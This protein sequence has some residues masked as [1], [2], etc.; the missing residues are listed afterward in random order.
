MMDKILKVIDEKVRPFLAEHNGDIEVLR[1][2]NGI[3]EI[4]L[5]GACSGC[6]SSKFTV[7]ELVEAPLMAEIPEIKEVVLVHYINEETMQFARKI[8]HKNN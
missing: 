6:M 5:L 1:F 4:K 3:L 2:Q 8:L 7:E